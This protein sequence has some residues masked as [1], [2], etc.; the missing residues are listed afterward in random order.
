MN[1]K[2][3]NTLTNFGVVSEFSKQLFSDKANI[4]ELPKNYNIFLEGKKNRVEYVLISGVV[5]RYNISEKGDV[6]TTGF[7]MSESVITP[8]F[9]RTNN[10][11]SIF[12]LETLTDV[13][14][15][16]ILVTDLDNLRYTNKEFNEFGQRIIEAEFAQTIYHETIF[17]SFNAKERLLMLRKQF[18]NLENLIP[19]NIIASYL[20]IT[21]VS[22]SR[23]R[24]ERVRKP[25]D[26]IK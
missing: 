9:A 7:Y 5:H 4:V 22:L 18:P 3:S 12:S 23:L 24:N 16:E 8:H 1:K 14:L 17:R 6:V 20:G 15:A 19:H 2:L 26:F 10:G 25:D 21:N 13:A 11:K